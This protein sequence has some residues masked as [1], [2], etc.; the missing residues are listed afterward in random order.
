MCITNSVGYLGKNN[1]ADVKVVQVLFN[2]NRHR[3]LKETP[4]ILVTD[5]LIGR[6]TINAISRFETDV[7]KLDTSDGLITHGDETI[8]AFLSGLPAGFSKDK[9]VAIIPHAT[10][11]NIGRYYR[12]LVET[13]EKYEINTDLRIAHFIAQLAHESGS[14]AYDEEIA[15]GEAYEGRADLGNTQPGDGK[16]FK[17]RGLIQLTGRNNYQQY[18]TATG[19]DYVSNPKRL[20]YDPNAAVDV[21]GWF[22]S[23][24]RLNRY[25]DADDVRRVTRRINGGY[26]GLDDR[27]AFLG[28]AKCMLGV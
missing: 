4:A 21:A 12:P 17:G 14:L 25:A 28:R 26:N 9:L 24:R 5:G 15:S 2:L 1:Y 7:M 16:R 10:E 6:N 8:N 18:S 11:D 22:W 27:I 3:F 19:I 23:T 13:M 20:S